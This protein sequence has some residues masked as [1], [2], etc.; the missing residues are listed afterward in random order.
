MP[1]N[2]KPIPDGYT[3]VTPYIT[4]KGAPAAIE[5]YKKAFGA[6]EVLRLTAPNGDIAHAEIR[7]GNAHIMLHEEAPDWKALSP[8][9]IGDSASSIMLY[10]PDCDAVFQRAVEAGAS[11]TMP[12]ADQFYGDRCGNVK[13]PFGH[14]WSIATHIEDVPPDE[15]ERRAAKMFAEMAQKSA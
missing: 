2:V 3:S 4:I 1:A 9:T 13:D 7:I 5:F 8:Q 10:V 12:I 15:I 14:K 6:E 11:V